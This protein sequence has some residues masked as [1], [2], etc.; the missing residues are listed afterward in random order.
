MAL[1]QLISEEVEVIESTNATLR[2]LIGKV[3][4]ES[5]ESLSVETKEGIRV[6]LKRAI[7][8]KVVRTKS[9]IRGKDITKKPEDRIK[10]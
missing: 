8:I 4:D 6:L 9:I 3:I 1:A 7:S 2:G 10:G 5:K